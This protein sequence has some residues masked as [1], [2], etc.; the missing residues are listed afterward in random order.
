MIEAALLIT[1][2]IDLLGFVFN[3]LQ[4]TMDQFPDASTE[5]IVSFIR[6][7]AWTHM[8]AYQG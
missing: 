3:I 2:E 8:G 1:M 6:W 5:E 7:M 4:F